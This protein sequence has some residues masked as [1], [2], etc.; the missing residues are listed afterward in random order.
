MANVE[1]RTPRD[2]A[3]SR[4]IMRTV[5]LAQKCSPTVVARSAAVMSILTESVLDDGVIVRINFTV[6][7]KSGQRIVELDCNMSLNDKM[8][9]NVTD[10][11]K[12]L[13]TTVNEMQTR[14][15]SNHLNI[16]MRLW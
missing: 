5:L 12:L 3:R 16:V 11:E 15:I 13:T 8:S 4:H 14:Y 6:L 9:L 7:Y 1:V 10:I 2:V